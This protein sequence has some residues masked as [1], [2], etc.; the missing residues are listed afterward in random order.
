[1]DLPKMA[2]YYSLITAQMLPLLEPTERKAEE[3]ACLHQIVST[4]GVGL[5]DQPHSRASTG[6]A[7]FGLRTDVVPLTDQSS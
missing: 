1:M 2:V 3:P 4:Q 7:S 5:Q 6:R